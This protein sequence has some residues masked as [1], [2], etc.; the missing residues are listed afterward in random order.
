MAKYF[1]IWNEASNNND[2]FLEFCGIVFLVPFLFWIV[3]C[4]MVN[5]HAWDTYTLRDQYDGEL[6]GYESQYLILV[7]NYVTT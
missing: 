4:I 1:G 3:E 5:W 2:S 6:C 7:G